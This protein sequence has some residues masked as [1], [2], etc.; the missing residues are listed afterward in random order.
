[1]E[2]TLPSRLR[3]ALEQAERLFGEVHLVG[4]AVRDLVLGGEP[5]DLDFATPLP[6]E[7]VARRIENARLPV[8]LSGAAWG[9][10]FTTFWVEDE[11]V[12]VEITTYR[13]EIAY[14]GRHPVVEW[15]DSVIEDLAR[16][17]F[18]VNAMALDSG[19][20]ASGPLWRP[21]GHEGGGSPGGG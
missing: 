16:R 9:T 8:G 20:K 7:E 2:I 5:K 18:T 11:K 17:D 12:D 21:S 19:G 6:P 15:T 3:K 10:V 1:M 13:R 14:N 4:G